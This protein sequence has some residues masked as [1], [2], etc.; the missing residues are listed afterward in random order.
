M[1]FH[2]RDFRAALE[3]ARRVVKAMSAAEVPHSLRR[4]WGSSSRRMTPVEATNLFRELEKDQRLR[5]VTLDS[6][7]PPS[8]AEADRRTAA[9]VL[10][11][12][13]TENWESQARGLLTEIALDE[14]QVEIERLQ[15]CQ[16]DAQVELASLRVRADGFHQQTEVEIKRRTAGLMQD[17]ERAR[18]RITKLERDL[19]EQRRQTEFWEKEANA[20]F[21]QLDLADERY[22]DLRDRYSSK[23]PSAA[24][25][26]VTSVEGTGFSRDPLQAARML[27]QMVSFW[28]V[29][30]D[31]PAPTKATA[32]RLELPPGADPRSSGAVD[33][34]FWEAP[35]AM[36]VVD[37]WNVA[38]HWMYQRQLEPPPDQQ[39]IWFVTNR[40][41]NLARYSIGGHRVNFYL[42]S[43]HASGIDLDWENRFQSGHLTGFYVENADDAIAEEAGRR[44]GEPVLVVTSDKE[45]AERCRVHGAMV[46]A[47]EGLAEWMAEARV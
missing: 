36:L 34:V 9:S 23:R 41:A 44:E 47:S 18:E 45:L 35:R 19:G 25:S 1:N 2:P 10:F 32:V 26:G 3:E 33:W 27:D 38:Y 21:D 24:S 22:D 17:L 12:E 4:T 39:T 28:E 6:W 11:L 8:P 20:A 37:G 14:A 7:D 15:R 5:Q 29:G 16:Q 42:D 31:E 13:R 40:L 30:S 46:L 43:R